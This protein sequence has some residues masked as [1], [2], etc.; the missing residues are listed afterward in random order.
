[1]YR[2]ELLQNYLSFS[3]ILVEQVETQYQC[4]NKNGY[5]HVDYDGYDLYFVINIL[6]DK[7]LPDN[8]WVP[9]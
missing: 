3:K 2:K 9:W 5:S 8:D 6:N 7:I 4:R 1:M